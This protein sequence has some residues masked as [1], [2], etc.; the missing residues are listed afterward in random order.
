MLLLPK[1]IEVTYQADVFQNHH[2]I[3]NIKTS[4]ALQ[5][6]LT[7]LVTSLFFNIPLTELTDLGLTFC[8][9]TDILYTSLGCQKVFLEDLME[10]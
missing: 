9:S 3:K 5:L 8:V 10:I 6:H 4:S 1:Y 7:N 2:H